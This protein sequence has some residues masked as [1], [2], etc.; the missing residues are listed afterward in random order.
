ML[1]NMHIEGIKKRAFTSIM[2][3]MAVCACVYFVSIEE[4]TVMESAAVESS[5]EHLGEI[6]EGEVSEGVHMVAI[7]PHKERQTTAT[8]VADMMQMSSTVDM[9]KKKEQK[10]YRDRSGKPWQHAVLRRG[11]TWDSSQKV[12]SGFRHWLVHLLGAGCCVP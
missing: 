8:E 12:Q 6:S 2:L 5:V 10:G 3:M 11:F 7:Y 4:S 9:G 1:V